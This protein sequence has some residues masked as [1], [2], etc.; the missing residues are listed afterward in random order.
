MQGLF[1]QTSDLTLDATGSPWIAFSD[2]NGQVRVAQRNGA[3]WS[4]ETAG[5]GGARGEEYVNIAV[6][7]AG[8]AAVSWGKSLTQELYCSGAAGSGAFAKTAMLR[9][10][11]H[12]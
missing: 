12:F 10:E 7:A 9:A 6:G 3:S 5:I 1:S 8:L 11:Y 2:E 4:F